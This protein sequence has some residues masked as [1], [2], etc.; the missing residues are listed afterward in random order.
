MLVDKLYRLGSQAVPEE[1]AGV[2][3]RADGLVDLAEPAVI[4]LVGLKAGVGGQGLP[5]SPQERELGGE[6]VPGVI[7]R[8][9]LL[10]GR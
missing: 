7:I 4:L 3:D 5:D 1:L 10:R 9:A 6:A 2:V 8:Q